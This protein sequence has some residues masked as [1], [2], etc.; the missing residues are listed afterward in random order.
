MVILGCAAFAGLLL[1]TNL[2]FLMALGL[3][4][5]WLITIPY[6]TKLAAILSFSLLNSS[7]ILPFVVQRPTLE[8]ASVFLAWTGIIV[9]FAMRRQ[10]PDSLIA[11]RYHRWIWLSYLAF[12]VLVF[13]IMKYRDVGFG[14][15]GA[16]QAGGRRYLRQLLSV[17]A[18]FAFLLVMPGEK[19]LRW[20][21]YWHCLFSLTFVVAEFA[22][23]A[24]GGAFN[25]ILYFVELPYDAVTFA[26]SRLSGIIDRYQSLQFVCQSGL[27]LVCT[28]YSLNDISRRQALVFI[29]TVI[30]MIGL[31]LLSGH[32]FAIYFVAAYL[33]T[34]GLAQRFL[35][36]PR[37]LA[38]LGGGLMLIISTYTI[39][40]Q[41]PLSI[42]RALC[43]LP[44]FPADPVAQFNA[45]VTTSGRRYVRELAWDVAPEY[46]WIGRGFSSFSG[47]L[48]AVK[49][50]LLMHL[51]SGIWYNGTISLMINTGIPGLILGLGFLGF[52]TRLCLQVIALC[53][54]LGFDDP[55]SRVA[56]SM[57]CWWLV[58][59]F[60]LV[61]VE[62][63]AEQ[64]LS[65]FGI[66]TAFIIA[67][68]VALI[69]RLENNDALAPALAQ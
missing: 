8:E 2:F 27:V 60:S 29:P 12:A 49:D 56:C 25:F 53:R 67:C 59:A 48:Q 45:E 38:C 69:R 62:G 47:D 5:I 54:R 68:Q 31:G 65:N 43:V 14:L 33:V 22:L 26:S 28:F 13:F 6:H 23:T 20:L 64:I 10:H 44:A 30:L 50:P 15:S 61:F 58:L 3:M 1:A 37:L 46:R 34:Q 21:C 24:F 11:I 4:A 17:A 52:G 36:V 16:T 32:R 66:L 63:S 39:A 7:F 35:N 51:Q 40:R 19:S 41:L 18:P 55:F 57:T 42:Q 9:T